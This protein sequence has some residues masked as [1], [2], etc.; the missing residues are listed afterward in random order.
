[1]PQGIGAIELK[2]SSLTL[3]MFSETFRGSGA[4]PNGCA[5][6]HI[7]FRIYKPL[8]TV[9]MSTEGLRLVWQIRLSPP[10][11]RGLTEVDLC[12][13][14]PSGVPESR[15]QPCSMTQLQLLGV[16][17]SAVRRWDPQWIRMRGSS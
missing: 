14:L 4:I 10:A 17:D 15:R 6:G 13:S 16:Q 1:M 5:Q 8:R 3:E 7:P 11:L 12:T 2:I 9:I